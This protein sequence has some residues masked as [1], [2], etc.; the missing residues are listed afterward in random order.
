ME[1][2]Y[3][4]GDCGHG[5]RRVSSGPIQH[6]QSDSRN[7]VPVLRNSGARLRRV[8]RAVRRRLRVLCAALLAG[9]LIR[10]GAICPLILRKIEIRSN[11]R[12][13]PILP[14]R[15]RFSFSLSECEAGRRIPD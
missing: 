8:Q 10:Y 5:A 1:R 12:A 11:S 9:S 7:T 6:L 4:G 3:G 15:L 13:P 2:R 14:C